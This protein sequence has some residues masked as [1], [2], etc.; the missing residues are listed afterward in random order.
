MN[1]SLNIEHF[2]NERCSESTEVLVA[3]SGGVD[4]VVLLDL[5]VNSS[6]PAQQLK[7]IYVNHGLSSNSQQWGEFCQLLCQGYQV[8][9]SIEYVM[10][11]DNRRNI[12]AMAREARYLAL[13]KHV[14]HH[15]VLVT[16]QHSDDQTETLLLA[17]KRGSGSL[18]LAGMPASLPFGLGMHCRPLLN[19]S[20]QAI[21]LYAQQQQLSWIEDE[22]NQ[23]SRF[24]RNFLR[25]EIIPLL[26][27]RWSGFG[28]S[29]ARSA[30]LLGQANE[31]LDELAQIDL[32][33][34]KASNHGLSISYL[35][36]LS[37]ARRSNVI[38]FWLRCQQLCLP[39][40]AQLQQVKQQMMNA[41]QDSSP[42]VCISDYQLRR[43][44]DAIIVVQRHQDISAQV[45]PWLGQ[46][47][48]QLPDSLGQLTL[49]QGYGA[50]ESLMTIFLIAPKGQK[51]EIRF[52]V[53]G[54]YKAWP[55][56]REQ[57]RSVKKLWQEFAVPPWLRQRTPLVFFD[58]QLVAVLGVWIE[59]GYLA[60]ESDLDSL[61]IGWSKNTINQ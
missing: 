33:K 39:S 25:N 8:T 7:V 50:N 41:A 29:V 5:L 49:G 11:A 1:L 16:A 34:A 15:T 40:M 12:E 57:R 60:Q 54:S 46:S 42:N 17:L 38:R 37:L 43:Y 59:Q 24:D 45:I 31:L 27:Q 6:L 4:S 26:N 19:V 10:L 51:V 18:G 3:L 30:Q 20:R 36:S 2:I 9:F 55:V 14:N 48:I 47:Q 23:D 52:N 21:E 61:R 56:G 53:A 58:Q 35:K 28:Q 22:S 32:S 13:K 44:Q